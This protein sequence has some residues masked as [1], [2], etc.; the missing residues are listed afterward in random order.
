[1]LMVLKKF[2]DVTRATMAEAITTANGSGF[3]LFIKHPGRLK[4]QWDWG[5]IL[6]GSDSIVLKWN[7][8]LNILRSS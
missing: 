3:L 2:T 8:V 1:M 5:Y 4:K 6:R 7:Q